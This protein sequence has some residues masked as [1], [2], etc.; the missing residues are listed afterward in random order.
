VTFWLIPGVFEDSRN[1]IRGEEGP[2]EH[3]AE[4]FVYLTGLF[5]RLAIQGGKRKLVNG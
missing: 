1:L 3:E 2:L 5:I 4:N